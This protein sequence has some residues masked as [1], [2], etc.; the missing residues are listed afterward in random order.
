M[1]KTFK[2]LGFT[3]GQKVVCLSSTSPSYRPKD[4]F[5]LKRFWNEEVV[6][7]SGNFHFTGY[8]GEWALVDEILPITI[9]DVL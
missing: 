4:V 7:K 8:K 5:I 3:P 1:Y 9:E 6:I 2:E